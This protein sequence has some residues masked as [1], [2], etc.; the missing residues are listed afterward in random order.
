ME[1]FSINSATNIVISLFDFTGEMVRP[2]AQ[3]G[4]ECFCYD[5]QHD[6]NKAIV[7][8]FTGGGSITFVYA[9]LDKPAAMP[10]IA[11]Q[12]ADHAV[13]MVFS[14]FPCDDLAVSG[15]AHFE[16]K[17]AVDPLFQR[18]A[19]KRGKDSVLLANLLRAPFMLENPVSVFSTLYRK[20]DHTFHPFEFGGYIAANNMKHPTWPEYIPDGDAYSKKTCLWTGGGFNMP[21]KKPVECESFGASKQHRKLGG[22]SK[23]TKNIRSATPRGFAAAVYNAN[24]FSSALRIVLKK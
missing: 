22:K 8:R 20:P 5:I 13:N 21:E 7:E 17:R 24:Y 2:W 3:N 12:F 1:N 23:K 10:V 19:A 9:D 14:F 15:A 16:R 4:F 6:P 18:K 11:R